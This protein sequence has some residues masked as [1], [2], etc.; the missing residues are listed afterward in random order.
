MFFKEITLSNLYFQG[1]DLLQAPFATIPNHIPWDV[2]RLVINEVPVENDPE[3]ADMNVHFDFDSEQ[4]YRSLSQS[5][6]I[7]LNTTFLGPSSPNQYV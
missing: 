6:N 4:A 3:L 5:Y 1:S 2:P 7:I